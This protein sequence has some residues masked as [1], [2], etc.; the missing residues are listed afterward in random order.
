MA[1]HSGGDQVVPDCVLNKLG[2]ALGV[3][4][5]H[6]AVLVKG[7]GSGRNIQDVGHFLHTFSFRQQL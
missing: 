2:A 5:L 6:N 7:N 3:K 4:D 1:D